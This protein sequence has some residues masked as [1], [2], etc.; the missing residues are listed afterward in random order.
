LINTW[1]QIGLGVAIF[2]WGMYAFFYEKQYVP[3]HM[4]PSV[5]IASSMQEMGH[6]GDLTAIKGAITLRNTSKAKVWI[7]SSWY[8]AYGFHI[9]PSSMDEDGYTKYVHAGAV[10]QQGFFPRHFNS[11][12]EV[13]L[14]STLTNEGAWLEP[15][16]EW[17][18]QF[19]LYVPRGKYESLMLEV[20]VEAAK[21]KRI[22]G[23]KW[24][25]GPDKDHAVL[26]PGEIWIQ[27]CVKPS[28]TEKDPAKC[29][30]VDVLKT[31]KYNKLATKYS[32]FH[33]DSTSFLLLTG[34]RAAERG[35][36][37]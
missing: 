9:T 29:E 3:N 5:V 14:N 17:N 28:E 6:A 10:S 35:A 22:L 32:L 1:V 25:V 34:S 36:V 13:V 20:N 30:L 26:L 2:L 23:T 31:T 18:G 27:P 8:T 7:L 33:A 21:D 16:E 19:Q 4:P 15:D 24:L 12:V 37:Q 11:T